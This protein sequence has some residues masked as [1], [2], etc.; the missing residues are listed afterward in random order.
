MKK[1]RY[2][3][4]AFDLTQQDIHIILTSSL[5]SE[6]QARILQAAEDH[7]DQQRIGGSGGPLMCS[8][9]GNIKMANRA[10]VVWLTWSNTSW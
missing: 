7:V 9:I 1:F 5:T 3:S 10:I 6:E 4:Q 8:H 2:L